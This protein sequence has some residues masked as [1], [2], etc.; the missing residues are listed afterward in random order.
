MKKEKEVDVIYKRRKLVKLVCDLCLREFSNTNW[1]RHSD[2]DVSTTVELK[3]GYCAYGD[4]WGDGF[5]FHICPD[6]FK[7]KLIP[8]VE[9]HGS[10]V[11]TWRW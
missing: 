6:C 1:D 5:E 10:R 8:W 9:S 3:D 7:N 11:T 4:A 2:D